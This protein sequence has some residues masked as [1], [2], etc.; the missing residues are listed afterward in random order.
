MNKDVDSDFSVMRGKPILHSSQGAG[1]LSIASLRYESRG[2]FGERKVPSSEG[3]CLPNPNM[4]EF[5]LLKRW[6]EVGVF[7]SSSGSEG[8]GL[9]YAPRWHFVVAA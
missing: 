7:G 3:L 6:Y 9:L 5:Y 1:C 8:L 2:Y 4:L